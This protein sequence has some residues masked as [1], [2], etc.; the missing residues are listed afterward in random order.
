L[1]KN[2]RL[3]CVEYIGRKT[4]ENWVKRCVTLELSEVG[5]RDDA[6]YRIKWKMEIKGQ[7]ANTGS[8]G[9]GR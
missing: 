1:I 8:P 7:L 4:D 6:P 2:G 5:G 3:R 9:K